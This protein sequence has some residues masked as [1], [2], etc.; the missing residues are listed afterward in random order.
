MLRFFA[1]KVARNL[2]I[3]RVETDTLG[4]T[5]CTAPHVLAQFR[6]PKVIEA[7][8]QD[9]YRLHGTY[10]WHFQEIGAM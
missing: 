4:D 9:G 7:N 5:Y 3:W 10:V 6:V 2:G 8:A 1:Q